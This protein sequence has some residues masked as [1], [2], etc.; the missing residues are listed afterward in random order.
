MPWWRRLYM[1][2]KAEIGAL[3]RVNVSDRLWQMPVAAALASGLPLLVG[4]WFDHLDYGLVSS[5]AGLVFLYMP[6]T[7][8]SH[9]MVFLMACAF[10]MT[11][12][13]T[14]GVISHFVPILMMPTLIF[15]AV[16]AA[17]LCRFYG[18]GMPGSLFF[19]MVAS[20]GAYSPIGI[21]EVPLMVGLFSMG[22]LLAGLIGFFYSLH[23]LSLRP[24]QPVPER[25]PVNFESMVLE[26]VVFGTFVGLSLAAA[27]VLQLEKAYWVPVSCLAVIQGTSLRAVWT[28]KVHRILGTSVGLMVAWGLL[29]LPLDKWTIALV[30]MAL[31]FIIETAVV[32]HYAVAVVFIT[33]LTILL[34]EAATLGH[35][36]TAELVQARFFDTVLGCTIGLAGGFCLHDPRLRGPLRAVLLRLTPQRLR[37]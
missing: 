25:P 15:I 9:R 19:I 16:L 28:K 14:L 36:P 31:S 34:A 1:G 5:L 17:M 23:A 6:P 24:A 33:P 27:Q 7:P 35:G 8:L 21:L 37:G 4:A 22:T 26:P 2:A 12:C 32:R 3:A 30:M 18:V 20:I 29:S 10:A 13:Y 11:A